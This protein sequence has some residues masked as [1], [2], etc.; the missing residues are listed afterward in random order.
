MR[1]FSVQL[2][3]LAPWDYYFKINLDYLVTYNYLHYLKLRENSKIY[4]GC[5]R[6]LKTSHNYRS[7]K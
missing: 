5:E 4:R 7:V 1:K 3:G 6:A 2:N